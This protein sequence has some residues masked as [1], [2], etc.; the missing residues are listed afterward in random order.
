MRRVLPGRRGPSGGPAF[1]DVLG[2]CTAWQDDVVVVQPA[3]GEP[4]RIPIETIVSGK[5]VPARPAVRLRVSTA[6]AEAH[7][8]TLFAGVEVVEV[9][10]WSARWEPTPPGRLRKR[11]NS[12]L[13][14]TAPRSSVGA[15]LAAVEEFYAARGRRALVQVEQGSSIEVDVA[16]A[17]WRSV[18]GDS[19]FLVAG[20]GRIARL[21]APVAR[22]LPA[23]GVTTDGSTVRVRTA[24]FRAE[25]VLDGDWLGIHG[26]E[27]E[28]AH[29]RRG[30]ARAALAALAEWGAERG[31]RTV[32]LHVET[33]NS[34][35]RA[36]YDSLEFSEHHRCRY[37][38][39]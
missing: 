3:S 23:D 1:T 20:L 27:V 19:V 7:T 13:A 11:A 26:L 31:A 15:S 17:G 37:Y 8:A 33:D 38:S 21:L 9:A 32:W 12:A 2:I 30:L 39:R 29:R 25:A 6:D 35:A 36:L 18:P 16:A 24:A 14:M 28:P 34:P 4:V 22:D 10:G 5:P